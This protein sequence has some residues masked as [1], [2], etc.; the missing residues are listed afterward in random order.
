MS[1][2]ASKQKQ[3]LTHWGQQ[4]EIKAGVL[5]LLP[6]TPRM[7]YTDIYLILMGLL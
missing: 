2:L 5:D 6:P 4:A 7:I 3:Y 1:D